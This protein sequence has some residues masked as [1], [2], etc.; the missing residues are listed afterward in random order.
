MR[1][2]YTDHLKTENYVGP[3]MD[4]MFD[5]LGHSASHALNLDRERLTIT[6]IQSYDLKLADSE[7]E[8]RN[9]HWLLVH[10]FYLSLKYIPGL[11]KTWYMECRSKQTTNAVKDWM[12]KN[13]TPIIVSE[14]LNEVAEWAKN[15][16]A[17]AD[18]EKELVIKVSPMAREITAGYEVDE[19]LASIAIRVPPGYPIDNVTVAGLNRVA[20]NERK[21]NSWLM[22][23]QG[24][25]TFS[26][27]WIL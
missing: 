4:F 9:L 8:E 5:V 15:Q 7:P 6:D 19:S 26:V 20:V 25:I 1:T 11:F 10:I 14:L 27:S 22:T 16:E 17:P 13:F 12:V 18:D 24:V 21:W 23:T 2:D 3:L